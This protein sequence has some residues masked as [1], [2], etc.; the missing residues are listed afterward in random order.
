MIFPVEA[1][2]CDI[3]ARPFRAACQTAKLFSV[4]VSAYTVTAAAV[5]FVTPKVATRRL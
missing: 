5:R 1:V 4:G 2:E 3:A